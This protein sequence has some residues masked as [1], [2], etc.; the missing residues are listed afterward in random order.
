LKL[1]D[2]DTLEVRAQVTLPERCSIA[3]MSLTSLPNGEDA[4]ILLGDEFSHQYRWNPNTSQLSHLPSW[5]RRYRTRGD[6]TFPGTGPAIFNNT[7]FYTDNTFPIAI[8]GHSYSMFSQSID[9]LVTGPDAFRSIRLTQPG[10]SGFMFWSITVSPLVGDVI[11]WDSFQNSVQSRY[12][13]DLSLHWEIKA[14]H[15]DVLV[16]AADKGHVYLTDFHHNVDG[17]VADFFL[18]IRSVKNATKFFIIADTETGKIILNRTLS[19]GPGGPP[20]LIVPSAHN[21]I[22]VSSSEGITRLYV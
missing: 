18:G 13:Y 15:L 9:P 17:P 19:I 1:V 8:H 6:G 22:I 2:P 10:L 20:S 16:V 7:A 11:V 4:L 21:D 3:R 14:K 5:S 12:A